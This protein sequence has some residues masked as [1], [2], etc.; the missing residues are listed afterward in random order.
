[1]VSRDYF[2]KRLAEAGL[3]PVWILAGEKNVY[4]SQDLGVGNGFGGRLHH[5]TVF[6]VDG[7]S[8][9]ALGTKTDLFRPS[10]A[11]LEALRENR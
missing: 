2:L 9:R 6:I 7:G 10:E 1:V 3:E 5:T 11:Q 8:L 4:A